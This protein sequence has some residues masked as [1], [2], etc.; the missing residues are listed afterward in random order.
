[1]PI[2]FF[3]R[4]IRVSILFP[5]H[6]FFFHLNISCA[7]VKEQW[8][9]PIQFLIFFLVLFWF[10]PLKLDVNATPLTPDF[11]SPAHKSNKSE[12]N[13]EPSTPTAATNELWSVARLS[14]E[15]NNNSSRDDHLRSSFY[16]HLNQM[17]Q[18]RTSSTNV[19]FHHP[20]HHLTHHHQHGQHS[21]PTVHSTAHSPIV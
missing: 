12:V 5:H 20:L 13:E 2:C 7:K 8:Y 18:Q 11:L 9:L 1:M 15:C 10:Q 21:E 4:I 14:L 17:Q 19:P 16:L 6:F 3:L